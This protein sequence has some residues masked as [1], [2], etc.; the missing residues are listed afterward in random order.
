MSC[1]R[2]EKIVKTYFL[3]EEIHALSSIDFEA[4]S[5][6]FISIMGTSGS[7]KSTFMH[8]LGGLDK[9]TSGKVFINDVE[10]SSMKDSE[11]SRMRSEKIGFV[12]QDFSLINEM[13]AYENIVLPVLLS[14]RKPD[15]E[16]ISEIC[17]LLGISERLNHRPLEMSGGQQQ[18]V[19]IARALGNKPDIILCDEPTGNLDKKS[20]LEVIEYFQNIHELYKKTIIMVTHDQQIASFAEKIFYIEDGHLYDSLL[21]DGKG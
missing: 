14:G 17:D 9:P 4:E 19:A 15:N 16:Y 18:R 13:T 1:I 5:G 3:G 11:L 8:M 7:G 2:T 21:M 20:S 10:I 12:F 6:S